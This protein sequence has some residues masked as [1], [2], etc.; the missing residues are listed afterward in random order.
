MAFAA[1]FEFSVAFGASVTMVVTSVVTAPNSVV[2]SVTSVASVSTVLTPVVTV[3]NSVE[4]S[5]SSVTSV[6]SPAFLGCFR[7]GLRSLG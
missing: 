2:F 3:P 6:S 1:V 7:G 5:V 4:F